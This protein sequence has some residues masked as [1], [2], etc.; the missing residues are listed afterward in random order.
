MA[1][2]HVTNPA[3]N[4][5]EPETGN[6]ETGA[7]LTPATTSVNGLDQTNSNAKGLIV[8][9]DITAITGTSVTVTIQG[10]DPTS[11]KYYTIL[12][13]AA[14]TATGT[15]VMRVYPGLVASANVTANDILPRTWRVITTASAL[16]VL[17]ATIAGVMID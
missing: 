6:W 15:T 2:Q 12:A 8:I 11:G 3:T 4:I 16:T 13:S 7:L 1:R 14:L 17:T 5:A 9:V 10:K